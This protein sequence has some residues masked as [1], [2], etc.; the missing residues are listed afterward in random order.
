MYPSNASSADDQHDENSDRPSESS[1]SSEPL[2]ETLDPHGETNAEAASGSLQS[3]ESWVGRTIARYHILRVLGVGGMGMV[4]EAIDTTIQRHVALKILPAEMVQEQIARQRFLEEARAVGKLS[5]P[6]VVVLHEIGSDAE[7]HFIVM[8][9]VRGGTSE[10]YCHADAMIS[11]AEATKMARQAATGLAAAHD[12]GIVHR[13]IKPANL[14][15]D[16]Q[17]NV[18]VTDFGLAKQVTDE[19][20]GMTRDGQIIG[21]PSY[22]SP[23]QCESR[24]VDARSDIYSLG[25][26]YYALLTGERPYAEKTS[27][28]TVMYAHCNDPPPDPRKKNPQVPAA[29]AAVVERAMAKRPIDR[30]NTMEE[31]EEALLDVERELEGRTRSSSITNRP[32]WLLRATGGVFFVAFMVALAFWIYDASGPMV[33]RG[34]P[35]KVGVLHSLSGTMADSERPVVDA[36]LLALETLNQ[37]GGVLGR[38]VEPIVRDGKSRA[39]QFAQQA[40]QLIREEQVVTVFGCWTS[41]SRKTIVPIF[42]DADHLLV[43]P[44]QYEGMEESPNVIYLGAAPNQQI[45]PAVDWLYREKQ[46]RNFFIVGS[47]YVFPR[48]AAEVI[49]DRVKE[50]GATVG[51]EIFLPLGTRNV[52]Q[53]IDAIEKANPDVILNLINGSTNVAFFEDLRS[54]GITPDKIP[55]ISFSVGESELARMDPESMAGDYAAWNY[56]QS[57][58]TPANLDFVESFKARYGP[59]QVI[60][61]P[62]EAAYTG[63]MLWAAA[64]T[65]AGSIE[66]GAIRRG[67]RGVRGEGPGGELRID[68]ATQHAYRKPRI[69]KVLED[70]QFEIIWEADEAV[71]PEPYPSSRTASAWRAALHDLYRGWQ[72]KWSA[73]PPSRNRDEN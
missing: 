65:E 66:P 58:D 1:G 15:L 51:G 31:M 42:E 49:E 73:P 33:P 16:S 12:A 25:A 48:M 13:D 54:R 10:Q 56:F 44:V 46:M 52:K 34:E 55:S 27:V 21:T 60:T 41:E 14:L 7:A 24:P 5:H 11:I 18:K 36:T 69:G 4:F 22:I 64:V 47:D 70:G 57:I 35:I 20:L 50:L 8:E 30:F 37:A 71:K 23:E 38:P 72:N 62:M 32:V 2:D 6:H 61:D 67:L 68:P 59:H 19:D 17:R 45:L 26:T 28:V 9:L 29:A 3:P 63:V 43:Y 40:E 53:A 39:G